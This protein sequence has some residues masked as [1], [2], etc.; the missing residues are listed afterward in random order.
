MAHRRRPGDAGAIF[1][2]HSA[3]GRALSRHRQ[4][5]QPAARTQGLSR[6]TADRAG[7][8]AAAGSPHRL[9]RRAESTQ[10]TGPRGGFC[11]GYRVRGRGPRDTPARHAA[12]GGGPA[13][14]PGK[15]LRLEFSV[16]PQAAGAALNSA[17]LLI[18]TPPWTLAGELKAI[19]PELEKPPG[20][21]GPGPVRVGD[22]KPLRLQP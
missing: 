7:A 15:C 4:G 8:A 13:A 1:G 5:L 22:P 10:P 9:R 3:A 18:V 11:L 2:N 19:L 21:G 12:G 6:I 16:A 20:P 14:P 17:G